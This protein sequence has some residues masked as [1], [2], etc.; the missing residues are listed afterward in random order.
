M[1]Q[2][3]EQMLALKVAVEKIVTEEPALLGR[4]REV[5]QMLFDEHSDVVWDFI[6]ATAMDYVAEAVTAVCRE[7]GRKESGR[8]V[9]DRVFLGQ[10]PDEDDVRRISELIE[11]GA[12]PNPERLARLFE[13]PVYDTKR[14]MEPTYDTEW[15]KDQ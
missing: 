4:P 2:S 1:D 11:K 14:L 3:I 9:I 7:I 8:D 6:K 10:S 15:L 12:N 13:K 5:T